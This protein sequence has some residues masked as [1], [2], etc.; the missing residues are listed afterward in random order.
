MKKR[1]LASYPLHFEKV[2]PEVVAKERAKRKPG[3][4]PKYVNLEAIESTGSILA[5]ENEGYKNEK[6]QRNQR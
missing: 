6:S 4:K 5:N 2:E 3:R 1:R